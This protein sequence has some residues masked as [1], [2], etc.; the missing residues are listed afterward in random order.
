VG[1][2]VAEVILAGSWVKQKLE[3]RRSL[4]IWLFN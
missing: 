4:S 1:R 3:F 2:G